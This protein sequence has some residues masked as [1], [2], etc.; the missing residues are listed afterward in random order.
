MASRSIY[1]HGCDSGTLLVGATNCFLIEFKITL[2]KE[3]H[4]WYCKSVQE[5]VAVEFTGRRGEPTTII[6][7]N[8]H[9]IKCR[10]K[11]ISGPVPRGLEDRKR[12]DS[13]LKKPSEDETAKSR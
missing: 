8:R 1:A 7:L 2:Q 4:A 5:M 10:A 3:I 6:L 13:S 11:I 12:P 9:N